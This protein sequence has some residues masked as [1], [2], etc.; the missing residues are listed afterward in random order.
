[1][2][3]DTT[4]PASAPETPT[5][6]STLLLCAAVA[7]AGAL[8]MGA[9]SASLRTTALASP[10]SEAL[11]AW[12]LLALAL[13]GGLLCLY[14]TAIWAL[15]ATVVTLG[16]ATRAGRTLLAPL[17]VLAPRLARRVATGAAVATAATALTLSSS[18]ASQLTIPDEPSEQSSVPA[19]SA[20]LPP[21]EHHDP[22]PAPEAAGDR[23]ASGAT[24]QGAAAPL[25]SLGWS[26]TAPDDSTGEE[27][28]ETAPE[29]QDTDPAAGPSD[30]ATARTVV[31]QDGDSLWSISED[32]VDPDGSDPALVAATWP[33]LHEANRDRIGADPD[34]LRPGQEL[35][36]PSALTTQDES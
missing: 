28:R 29:P 20:E 33:L 36:I 2:R 27:T 31:V 25:P 15:A 21:A 8:A 34:L 13:M 5:R 17:R 19:S 7:A 35:L 32:L 10:S 18:F 11:I 9:T 22:A 26:G 23:P 1:M 12:V 16:P 24:G 4:R 3:E 30:P 14:L 6:P